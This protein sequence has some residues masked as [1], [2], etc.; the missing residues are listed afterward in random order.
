MRNDACTEQSDL[1]TGCDE[2]ARTDERNN[3]HF[4]S[5][6]LDSPTTHCPVH[7]SDDEFHSPMRIFVLK[8]SSPPR[9]G[10]G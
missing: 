5:Q 8:A 1:L 4:W 9:Q 2:S 6:H 10:H 7:V 3:E